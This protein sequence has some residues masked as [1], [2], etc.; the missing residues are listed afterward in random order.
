M[1]M[2]P[3]TLP[4]FELAVFP[5][6]G[7]GAPGRGRG[8]GISGAGRSSNAVASGGENGGFS[9]GAAE[10]S[11]SRAFF[12]V[13]KQSLPKSIK[14]RLN[15]LINKAPQEGEGVVY[16]RVNSH[17]DPYIGKSKSSV[18]YYKRKNEHLRENPGEEFEFMVLGRADKEPD[19]ARIEEYFI[20]GLGG[21]KSRNP[22]TP[23]ANKR[24][25]MSIG[26]YNKAGGD[27]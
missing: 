2:P 4:Q 23:L 1:A 12:E 25:E 15:E 21:A 9:T 11:R 7:G 17:G 13:S 19:L 22:N 14:D 27:F 5:A 8:G 24:H 26:R 3:M 10:A 6:R 18:R 16:L 20:Q